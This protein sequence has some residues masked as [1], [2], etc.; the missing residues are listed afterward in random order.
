MSLRPKM[1]LLFGIDDCKSKP[2]WEKWETTSLEVPELEVSEYY[3]AYLRDVFF[4]YSRDK[5]DNVA[6]HIFFGHHLEG[7]VG[8]HLE[9]TSYDSMIVRSLITLNEKWK[10]EGKCDIPVMDTDDDENLC[11]V[12]DIKQHESRYDCGDIA[13]QWQWFYSPVI[14]MFSMWPVHAYC[15]RHLLDRAGIESDYHDYKA[16]LAWEWV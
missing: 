14:E 11:H 6:D 9:C 10:L 2:N 15:T 8:L 16:M 5:W 7:V 4:N 1:C 12:L 3:E 13:F